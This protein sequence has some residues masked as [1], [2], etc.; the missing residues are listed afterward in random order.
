MSRRK[1]MTLL[2]D[3]GGRAELVAKPAN[4]G[5]RIYIVI[6]HTW[7]PLICQIIKCIRNI[8]HFRLAWLS[9][10]IFWF[11]YSSTQNKLKSQVIRTTITYVIVRLSFSSAIS[12][13][14][15]ITSSYVSPIF[16]RS[17]NRFLVASD[18]LMVDIFPLFI[19]PYIISL[20][21]YTLFI[22]YTKLIDYKYYN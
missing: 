18:S 13:N 16:P 21:D 20:C 9:L 17:S 14:F 11:T 1:S 15:I 12:S 2:I 8:L 10:I 7:Q 4:S 3:A 19:I 6:T 22:W 5:K